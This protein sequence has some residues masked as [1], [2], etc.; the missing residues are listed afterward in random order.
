MIELKKSEE[1]YKHEDEF[2]VNLGRYLF[3]FYCVYLVT[4]FD[5]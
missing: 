5:I 2:K 3:I 4:K 1:K